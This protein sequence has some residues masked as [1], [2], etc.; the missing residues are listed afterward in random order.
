[1]LNQST[2]VVLKMKMCL[3]MDDVDRECDEL[4]SYIK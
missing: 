3:L 1:M 4:T 2:N